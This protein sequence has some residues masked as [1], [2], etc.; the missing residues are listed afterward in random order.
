MT[1]DPDLLLA[2][3]RLVTAFTPHSPIGIR[4]LFAGRLGLVRRVSDS[5][6]APGVH[7]ALF[8]DRGVGKTSIAKIVALI[9]QEDAD[10]RGMRAIRTACDSGDTYSTIWRKVFQE[11]VVIERQLGFDTHERSVSAASRFDVGDSLTP[12]DVRLVIQGLPNRVLVIVDEFD[13]IGDSTT[14]RLMAD[15]IKLFSDADVSST[16]MLV[17]VAESIPELIAEHES[18]SRNLTQVHVPQMNTE[19]LAEIVRRGFGR[20]GLSFAE[21][22]DQSIAM[23]S[24]GY[25]HYT[26]LLGL[27]AA[28]VALSRGSAEVSEADLNEAVG[29]AL[30]DAQ[31]SIRD[32]YETA[33]R[34]GYPGNLFREV[35]L[36]CALAQKDPLGSF[37]AADLRAPLQRITNRHYEI[38]AFQSHLA[39]FCETR[40]GPILKRIGTRRN[41]R[42]RF[43]NPQLIPYVVLQGRRAGII[44]PSAAVP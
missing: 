12:N 36:A 30:R 17:G 7:V 5:V 10:P 16:I 27:W 3:G 11:I 35:L 22:V 41:Y 32:E 24:Q 8:G 38:G 26:H 25:P 20:V 13:R 29:A 43:I 31:A 15:T 23:L 34:S 42:Y 28:R 33:V 6:A 1:G 37:A 44:D 2:E 14:R 19:E 39:Q 4:E 40:R 18:I 21:G 9:L